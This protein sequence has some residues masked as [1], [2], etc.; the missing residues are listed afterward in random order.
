MA[1]FKGFLKFDVSYIIFAKNRGFL[2]KITKIANN[3][4]SGLN[5]IQIMV[6]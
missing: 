2:V 1:F 4:I 5:S 6:F 3:F